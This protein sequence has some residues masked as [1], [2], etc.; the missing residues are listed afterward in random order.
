MTVRAE[1]TQDDGPAFI[2]SRPAVTRQ[3]ITPGNAA[4]PLLVRLDPAES[5]RTEVPG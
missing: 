2:L 5:R 3:R 4:W 1:D